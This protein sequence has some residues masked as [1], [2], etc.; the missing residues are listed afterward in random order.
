MITVV[1]PTIEG[2][3]DWLEKC[4]LAYKATS[5]PDTE[6]IIVKNEPSCGHAW[7]KGWEQSTGDY[8]HFTADDLQPL[9]GWYKK[10]VKWLEADFIP[11]ANVL[12]PN[13]SKAVCDAPLG[14]MGHWPNVLVPFLSREILEQGDWILPIH[15][16]SDDWVS[17]QAVKKGY[18]LERCLN[19]Q[20]IHHVANHGRNYLRR[21]QDVKTLADKMTAAGYLPPVYKQLEINLRDSATGL[22]NVRINQLDRDV[23][24]QLR[25]ARG[26]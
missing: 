22:D 2:R 1:I 25:L 5:P 14:D 13:M 16:G 12:T 10:P 4:L 26:R 9:E 20:L 7:Q 15:Y 23:R 18:G 11:A 6:Y 8:I 21:W 24:E 17:Y 19:Y 3:E